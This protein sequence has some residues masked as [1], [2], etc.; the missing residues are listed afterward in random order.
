MAV[1]GLTFLARPPAG[2][3]LAPRF[4][5]TDVMHD[6]GTLGGPDAQSCVQNQRGQIA[7][8]SDTNSTPNA[9]T[10]IPTIE[11]FLWQDGRLTD[12]G[13]LGGTIGQVGWLDDRGEVVGMSDLKGDQNAHPFLW[14]YGKMIDVGTPDGNFGF[15]N[16]INQRGDAAGAYLAS[17]GNFH[18]ILW[19][20]ERMIDL[21]PVGAAQ[22]FGNAVNDRGQVVGNQDDSNFNEVSAALWT[23]GHGYDLNT[24]VAPSDFQMLSADQINDQGTIFGHGV[25]TS[26]PNAGDARIFV[27]IR[28]P[29]VPLPADSTAGRRLSSTHPAYLSALILLAGLGPG[30]G[31]MMSAG[32][33]I[34]LGQRR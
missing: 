10:G 14:R 16:Y 1:P 24:L 21:R 27:L 33:R 28:N 25:Y 5:I 15:A 22:A 17:D 31:A 8:W 20:G 13:S 34:V 6:L 30:R 29:S 23:G 2:L 3:M 32:I 12:L 9:T 26:G 7:G 4:G 19:R 18:G 11:P